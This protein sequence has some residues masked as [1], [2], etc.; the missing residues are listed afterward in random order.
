MLIFVSACPF[1]QVSNLRKSGRFGQL[2]G[3]Y[4]QV[5][6]ITWLKLENG[7]KVIVSFNDFWTI[8]PNGALRSLWRRKDPNMQVPVRLT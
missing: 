7:D 6:N 4:E 2:N 3:I 5:D 8:I 1:L